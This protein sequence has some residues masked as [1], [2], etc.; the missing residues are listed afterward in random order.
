MNS[1]IL[2]SVSEEKVMFIL[3]GLELDNANIS[4]NS[5]IVECGLVKS[6]HVQCLEVIVMCLEVIVT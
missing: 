5:S 1:L 4:P 6:I 3:L 2:S